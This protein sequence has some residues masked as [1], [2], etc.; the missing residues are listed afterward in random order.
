MSSRDDFV[1]PP[2]SWMDI[3]KKADGVR[4]Q[5]NIHAMPYVPVIELIEKVFD[6]QLNLLEFRVGDEAEMGSAE[7]YTCPSGDFIMLRG[8][9]YEKA[10]D[11]DG[12]AR[13]TASHELGHWMLH[14]NVPLARANR[15]EKVRPFRLAEPQ[16][17][18]FAA[19]F[20]MPRGFIF[21]SDTEGNLMDRFGVS[22]EAASNRLRYLRRDASS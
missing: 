18:Q 15:S 4:R 11:G 9:V 5:F 20:L 21:P 22:C 8:D 3:A 13:F 12:R 10:C 7:G 1:F 16:A 14:T 17:N 2:L 19:E 6:Q